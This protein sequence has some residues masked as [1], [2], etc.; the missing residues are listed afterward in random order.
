MKTSL[1]DLQQ[2]F[3][4]F[5]GQSGRI[6]FAPGRVNLIGEHTDYSAGFVLPASL[7]AGTC[8]VAAPRD[9][10]TV[11][12]FSENQGELASFSLD[13]EP[14]QA[15]GQWSDYVAG[16]VW[17]L[18]RSGRP[19]RGADVLIASELPIGSGL[20]SSAALEVATAHALL[21]V[22]GLQM[23]PLEIALACQAAENQFV[24]ARCG[25]MDQFIAT[26]GQRDHALLLDCESFAWRAVP[27][28]ATHR[29]IVANTMVRHALAHGEY[30]LRRAEC[31]QIASLA[32]RKLPHRRRL[33]ELS[34]PEVE[35]LAQELSPT[36]AGRLRH[37]VGENAR[38]HAA[39]GAL[40]SGDAA[41]LGKLLTASHVSLRDDFEVS[42]RE[43]DAMVDLALQL[44]GVAGARMI[45][46]GFGGCTLSLVEASQ[47]RNVLRELPIQYAHAMGVEPAVYECEFGGAA[48][49]LA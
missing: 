8:V 13:I 6:A 16:V 40:E 31:E 43:L 30:N 22:A 42:C 7:A 29:W 5:A 45:G 26:H 20:S 48:G 15:R 33:A 9:D 3:R 27:L 14:A 44:P 49:M 41:T 32:L 24:G 23:A 4:A 46:G 17:A 2:R 18:Q 36:S 12:A 35:R 1:V 28:P 21:A 19:L 39:V 11:R 47:A 25:I 34:A 37:V 10:R 38:V